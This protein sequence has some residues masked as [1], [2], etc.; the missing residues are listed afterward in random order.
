MNLLKIAAPLAIAGA[1]AA[2]A[3]AEVIRNGHIQGYFTPYIYNS[4]TRANWDRINIE[5]PYGLEEIRVR[6]AP[7]DWESTG[8]NTANFVD[9]I[10]RSWCF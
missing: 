8:P 1:V 9:S 2:P 3:Q 7:F 5:G 4:P 10:A 6:C